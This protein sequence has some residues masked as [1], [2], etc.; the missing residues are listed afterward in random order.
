MTDTEI[1]QLHTL[2]QK[3]TPGDLPAL[4]FADI[5]RL[6]FSCAVEFVP[7][8]LHAGRIE[9]LLLA[10]PNDDPMW[11]GML[12]TPGTV[13][14]PGD[15]SFDEAFGRLL[16]S[17]LVVSGDYTITATGTHFIS[18]TRGDSILFEHVLE[19]QTPPAH[20]EYYPCDALPN[21]F[22][23]EQADLLARAIAKFQDLHQVN[24]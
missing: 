9:V 6:A 8:R 11:P 3:C 5:C 24:G 2:L 13:L 20:G 10:R 16:H 23:P 15:T 12:H 17:E 14:R 21:N 4:I 19:L 1:A 18:G 22:I 7:L